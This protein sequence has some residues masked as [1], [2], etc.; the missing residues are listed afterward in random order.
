ML[1]PLPTPQVKFV[2][3]VV[4]YMGFLCVY[5]SVLLV[6]QGSVQHLEFSTVELVFFAWALSLWISEMHQWKL[7]TRRGAC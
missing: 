1:T 7:N 3:S 2:T 6:R 4:S 5:V